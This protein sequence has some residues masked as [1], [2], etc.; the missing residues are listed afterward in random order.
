MSSKANQSIRSGIFWT[1]FAGGLAGLIAS[2]VLTI[3]KFHLYQNPDAV[4]NCSLNLVINCATVMQTWQ[5]SLLGFPNMVFGLMAYAVIVTIAVL[6]LAGVKLPRWFM[7]A[8][9]VGALVGLIFAEWLL[10]ESIYSIQVLCPWCLVVSVATVLIFASTVHYNLRQNNF[11]LSAARND[12][13]QKL[14]D[15]GYNQMIVIGWFVLIAVLIYM[16]FGN[17]LFL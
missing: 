11:R 8:A 7:L 13:V 3:E 12:R 6:G 16:Q 15:A 4:L 17:D 14:L 1:M 5:S 2:F 10:F 9:G